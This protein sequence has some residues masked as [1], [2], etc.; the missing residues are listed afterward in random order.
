MSQPSMS[1]PSLKREA[2]AKETTQDQAV[3]LV[4]FEAG[5]RAFAVDIQCVQDVLERPYIAAFPDSK[6]GMLGIANIRG[7]IVPVKDCG[8]MARMTPDPAAKLLVV[9][10]KP[11]RAFGVPVS[12]VQKVMAVVGDQT[13]SREIALDGAPV[14]YVCDEEDLK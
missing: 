9:E 10:L 11:G 1:L 2:S 13:R 5:G 6:P 3:A 8:P 7:R 14:R 4:R 12:R